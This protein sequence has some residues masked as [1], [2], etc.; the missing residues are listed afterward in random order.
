MDEDDHR[1]LHSDV[2]APHMVELDGRTVPWSLAAVA[3]VCTDVVR[4]S[5]PSDHVVYKGQLHLY[6][7]SGK[8]KCHH[9]SET[10]AR[11]RDSTTAF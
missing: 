3:V 7:S 6:G 4:L 9:Q 5:W 10:H 2:D 11:G 1:D 8:K